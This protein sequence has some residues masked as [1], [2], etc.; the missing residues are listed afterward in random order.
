MSSPGKSAI[1]VTG[2][3]GFIGARLSQAL[4]E[5]GTPVI[6]VDHL[7]HFESRPEIR[8]MEIPFH[9]RIERDQLWLQKDLEISAIV[10]LGACTDTFQ[11]DRDFLRK[12]NLEYSQK[13]WDLACERKIPLVYASSAATYGD[14]GLGYDDSEELIP[15]LHPLNPYGES[16]QAFDVWALEQE[17]R[18]HAPPAWSGFKFFNVYGFGERHKGRM[19]TVVLQAFDQIRETGELK[20]FKSHK[21]GIADGEQ[22]RDFVY[23]GDVVEVLRYALSK[24]IRRGIFNLGS[25]QARS[26]LDLGRAVFKELGRREN[27]RF[28]DTPEVLRSRYQY[29]T[30][31][32]MDRLRAEGYSRPFHSLEAGVRATVRDLS[33]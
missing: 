2:A 10:H 33:D 30:Q 16:K 18:G 1:L 6:G 26:F 31:A 3:A 27:I 22:K 11:L 9:G 19:A 20:L 4:G 25:G 15:R 12:V 24:P 17:R 32:R 28:I 13:I 8:E 21:A 29:F 14:G 7:A 23:V 5:S